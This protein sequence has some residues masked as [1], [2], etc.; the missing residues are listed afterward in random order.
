ACFGTP[1][2]PLLFEVAERPRPQHGRFVPDVHVV[3]V[4]AAD[5]NPTLGQYPPG[6]RVDL[7]AG[8]QPQPS[9]EDGS[10]RAALLR[11]GSEVLP[12]DID[13][14]E[15]GTGK[16]AADP[17]MRP[18]ERVVLGGSEPLCSDHDKVDV[19]GVWTE[20]SQRHGSGQVEAFHETWELIVDVPQERLSHG[21]YQRV[22]SHQSLLQSSCSGRAVTPDGV[23]TLRRGGI[24]GARPSGRQTVSKACI[25]RFKG[26]YS[27][28]KGGSV[29]RGL[30]PPRWRFVLPCRHAGRPLPGRPWDGLERTVRGAAAPSGVS[31]RSIVAWEAVVRHPRPA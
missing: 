14:V 5:G 2:S 15:V 30:R 10:H 23:R 19:A 4:R 27:C 9:G 17:G 26:R 18:P 22:D 31:D 1:P 13:A 11:V 29:H 3:R 16:T 28:F 24:R 25:S 20:V 12:G 7:G 8:A 6:D 21:S